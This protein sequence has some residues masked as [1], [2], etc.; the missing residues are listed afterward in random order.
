MCRLA[1]HKTF[2]AFAELLPRLRWSC[3]S[4]G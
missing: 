1:C 3:L 2:V 4:H